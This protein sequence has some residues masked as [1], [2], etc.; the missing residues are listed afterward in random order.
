[1]EM[2]Y[3][4]EPKAADDRNGRPSVDDAS[5]TTAIHLEREDGHGGWPSWRAVEQLSESVI[6]VDGRSFT[7]E[8][9]GN[10]LQSRLDGVEVRSIPSWPQQ[11]LE[12][13]EPRQVRAIIMNTG[14]EPMWSDA[15]V[16]MIDSITLCFP[17]VPKIILAVREDPENIA[18]A[19]AL[20]VKG[21]VPTSLPPPIVVEVV[22]LVCAGGSFA[23]TSALLVRSSRQAAPDHPGSE[24]GGLDGCGVHFSRRQVEILAC[25]HQGL[26]NKLIAHELSMSENTVKVHIRT[27]MKKLRA[28]NRT[29]VVC[30][31]LGIAQQLSA[32]LTS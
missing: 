20:G 14:V 2:P 27:I 16:D 5:G 17:G 31:T 3:G 22:R 10:F 32:D 25:L 24:E 15:V 26:S 4:C 21:Y 6:Y 28:T 11:A 8:C 18:Q 19:F 7:R 23:P 13:L 12:S 29:Q 1:M 9:I 30:L